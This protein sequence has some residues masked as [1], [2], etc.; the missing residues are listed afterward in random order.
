MTDAQRQQDIGSQIAEQVLPWE[1]IDRATGETIEAEYGLDKTWPDY[2]QIIFEETH[3]ERCHAGIGPCLGED[4]ETG[5]P[6]EEW[7]VCYGNWINLICQD[8]M[9]AIDESTNNNEGNTE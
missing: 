7:I 1:E 3:C 4:E 6:R 2:P 8:C 5:H 9:D